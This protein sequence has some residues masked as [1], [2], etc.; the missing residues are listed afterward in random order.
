MSLIV[1]LIPLVEIGA[2]GAAIGAAALSLLSL[3]RHAVAKR[4]IWK[5][6]ERDANVLAVIRKSYND[7]HLSDKEIRAILQTLRDALDSERA[8]HVT[9]DVLGVERARDFASHLDPTKNRRLVEQLAEEV[10]A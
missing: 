4:V 5:I 3:R 1:S 8:G 6:A 10:A 7:Q 9:T 2:S